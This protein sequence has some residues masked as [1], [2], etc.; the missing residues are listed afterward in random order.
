MFRRLQHKLTLIY[1]ALF[2]AVFIVLSGMIYWGVTTRAAET[3]R[4]EMEATAAAFQ[5]I[6]ALQESQLSQSA[7]LLAR[8]FGFRS[9]VATRDDPTVESALENLRGRLGVD[10]AFVLSTSGDM[11]GVEVEALVRGGPT[12]ATALFEQSAASGV[13]HFGGAAYQAVAVPVMAPELIGW[14][15]FARELTEGELVRVTE[16]APIPIT[17]RLFF[18]QG[19]GRWLEP[20]RSGATGLSEQMVS[21]LEAGQGDGVAARIRDG[22]AGRVISAAVPIAPFLADRSAVLVLDFPLNDALAPYQS[23]LLLMAMTAL[24]GLVVL[25]LATWTVARSLTRPIMALDAA[26]SQLA[27][28]HSVRVSSAGHDEIGRLGHSFNDMAEQIVSRERAILHSARHDQESGLPNRLALLETLKTLHAQP[29]TGHFVATIGIDR[30]HEIRNAI[31]YDLSARLLSEVA[32]NL[33]RAEGVVLAGRIATSALAVIFEASSRD[34]AEIRAQG[35]IAAASQ[36]VSLDGSVVDINVSLGLADAGPDGAA[37]SLGPLE[38]SSVALE[39]ARA[40]QRAFAFF[41]PELYGDPIAKLSLMSSMTRALGTDDIYLAYQPKLD[42]R[43]GKVSAMEALLRWRHPEQGFIPPDMFVQLA[44]ET[45]HIVPLTDWVIR[46]AIEDQAR[47]RRAGHDVRLS[48]NVS[49]RLICDAEF[50]ARNLILIRQ[51][52]AQLTF[53]ITETAVIANPDKALAVMR[54]VRE[55]GVLLSIDDYGAGLSNL[56]YLKSIPASELK[57][58]KAFVLSLDSSRADALLV[59]STID[60]AHSLGMEVTAEGVENGEALAMLAAM[61]AEYAQGYH[62]SR[63]QALDVILGW[64]DAQQA[65]PSS[66]EVKSIGRSR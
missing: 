49:G 28:G 20:A 56:S 23:I 19:S 53:E 5:Q 15:V 24:A 9:A 65:A 31:G 54:D 32:G 60:L 61:G 33:A 45:G 42:L 66:S 63:P 26:A 3:V 52:R 43:T 36:P 12:L 11:T 51:A 22:E 48:V 57:I 38:L 25:I 34:E 35:Q 62:I 39:Q 8:D 40:T 41:D 47:M 29:G 46:Q 16:L 44:E 13:A 64:L 10:V 18:R 21:A 55:A 37:G 4:G 27:A 14:V 6:W 30:F 7:S 1:S 58:D 17:A 59:K 50:I 2:A